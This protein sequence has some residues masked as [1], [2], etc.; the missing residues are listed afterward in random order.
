MSSHNT[1]PDTKPSS[2]VSVLK[3]VFPPIVCSIP[4]MHKH[5]RILADVPIQ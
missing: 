4:S 1:A 3:M 5:L 2:R